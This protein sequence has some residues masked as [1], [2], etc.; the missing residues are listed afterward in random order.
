MKAK[1][2]FSALS[3]LAA[4]FQP[5]YAQSLG[6]DCFLPANEYYSY[7]SNYGYVTGFAPGVGDANSAAIHVSGKVW[8]S[9]GMKP[10][11]TFKGWATKCVSYVQGSGITGSETDY[12]VGYWTDTSKALGK[13][14][15]SN[16][17]DVLVLGDGGSI[18][19]GF[20]KAIRNGAGYDFCV[21]ENALNDTFLELAF[22]EVSTDATHFVR[23]PNFYLGTKPVGSDGDV[24]GGVNDPTLIYNLGSKYRIGYGTG[25]DLQELADVYN[26]ILDHYDFD[27]NTAKSSS[28]FSAE[29]MRDFLDSYNYLDLDNVNYVRIGDIVGDG[30]TLDSRGCP[31][32]DAYPTSGTP[33]F[34]LSG[35]GVLNEVPEAAQCALFAALSAL[36]FVFLRKRKV[37]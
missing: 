26:Y 14:T 1:N 10:K 9:S 4:A 7:D 21:F 12:D 31:I 25:Y 34:D 20:D 16:T 29:Y 36:A 17:S 2:I 18:I 24:G 22:V 32:Y 28:M 37:S 8:T 6:I 19:L 27:T 3:I 33:G 5:L 15:A 30:T 23:F 13:P 35:V 11:Y